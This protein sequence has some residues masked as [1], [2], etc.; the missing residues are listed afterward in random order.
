MMNSMSKPHANLRLFVAAYPSHESARAMLKALEK[1]SAPPHKVTPREQVHL[2]IQF[3]GDV[4]VRDLEATT[5]SVQRAASGLERFMLQPRRLI[6]LPERG[7]ARLIAAETDAPAS[8]MELQRRLAIRLAS[9]VREKDDR[10]YRPHLT[11]CR[12]RAPVMRFTLEE[13]VD[14]E[15]SEV[16]RIVL[17][18]SALSPTGAQHHEVMTCE[19]G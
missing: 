5:E 3:I 2:T 13:V 15:G 8:L 1:L 14:I 7:P 17:M 11:L 9:H 4:P 6:S 16:S 18:R 19:L 12:F 10:P